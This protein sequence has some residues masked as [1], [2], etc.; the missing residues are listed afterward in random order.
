MKRFKVSVRFKTTKRNRGEKEKFQH[1]P[2]LISHPP[3]PPETKSE[4]ETRE[5]ATQPHGDVGT[6]GLTGW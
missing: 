3:L 1:M 2:P 6:A 5:G 4:L